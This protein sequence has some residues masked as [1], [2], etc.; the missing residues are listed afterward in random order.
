MGSEVHER[1]RVQSIDVGRVSA[2]VNVMACHRQY[3]SDSK[4]RALSA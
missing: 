4:N 1:I 2:G 3:S